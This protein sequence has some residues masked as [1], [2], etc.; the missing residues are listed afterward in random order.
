MCDDVIYH[1]FRRPD[2]VLNKLREYGGCQI[3]IRMLQRA[4]INRSLSARDGDFSGLLPQS[5]FVP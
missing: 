1:D 3:T 4:A 2:S 5:A